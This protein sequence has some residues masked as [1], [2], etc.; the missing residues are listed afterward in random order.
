[1]GSMQ[2]PMQQHQ[3][4]YNSLPNAAG[5]QGTMMQPMMQQPVQQLA[6]VQQHPVQ[7]SYSGAQSMQSPQGYDVMANQQNKAALPER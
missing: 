3:L 7:A 5:Q 2:Q 1:M 4:Q 6:Q